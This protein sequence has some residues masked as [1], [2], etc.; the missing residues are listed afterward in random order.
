MDFEKRI[1]DLE[2]KGSHTK[3]TAD[4]GLEKI[5]I[6]DEKVSEIH[7]GFFKLAE[8]LTGEKGYFKQIDKNSKSAMENAENI[9]IN[10]IGLS[11]TD[12]KLI[13]MIIISFTLG[14]AFSWVT[15]QYTLLF[16]GNSKKSSLVL[17]H[18]PFDLTDTAIKIYV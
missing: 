18:K 10:R 7:E 5:V 15:N 13:K 17:Y 8:N 16:K 11:K 4:E 9:D 2:I 6:L 3:R 14:M 1:Q 12:G